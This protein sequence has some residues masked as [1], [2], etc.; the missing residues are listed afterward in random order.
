MKYNT[1]CFKAFAAEKFLD[2]V[3]AKGLIQRCIK[4]ECSAGDPECDISE[5]VDNTGDE[6]FTAL[7]NELNDIRNILL[8]SRLLHFH[9]K[10]ANVKLNIKRREK[11][12]FKPIIRIFQN[13][14]VLAELLPVISNYIMQ[15]REVVGNSLHSFL[16]KQIK[17][18]IKD[19][20]KLMV[21]NSLIWGLI[22]SNLQ[23]QDIPGKP[24]SCDTQEFGII[25]QKEIFE[26][27]RDVFGTK[28]KKTNGIRHQ[29]FDT[30]RLKRL[31]KVYDLATEIKVSQTEDDAPHHQGRMG[32]IGRMWG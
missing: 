11:Q 7:R 14:S 9:R 3:K 2:P 20:K 10:I 19:Q 24:L 5:V 27:L 31:S 32:R 29:I 21:P 26:T 6:E 16:Y 23:G 12:L 17:D 28:H 13:S 18:I 1:Y 25:S 15:K 4:L 22:K 8:I 30:S